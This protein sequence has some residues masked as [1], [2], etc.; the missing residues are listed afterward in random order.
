MARIEYTR[1]FVDNLLK[2][3]NLTKLMELHGIDVKRGHGKND[4]YISW[5]CTHKKD[6][7]D[8]GRID[9]NKQTYKC[10]ACMPKEMGGKNAIHFLREYAGKSY[11]EAIR[12]LAKEAGVDIPDA[13]PVISETKRRKEQALKLAAEFYQAQGMLEYLLSRGISESV[14]KKHNAGYA[15]GGRALREHLEKFGFTKDEMTEWRLINHRGLDFHFHRAILPVYLNGKVVDLYG[16]ATDD[17]KA[18][19]KHL[20]LYGDQLGG[21]DK[22]NPKK[23]VKI[24]ESAID[25][26]VAESHGLDNGVD[27]GGAKKFTSVHAKLLK[28]KGVDK[29][30]IIFDGDKGGLEGALLT[31]ELLE[32][33]GIKVSVARLPEGMDPA[34]MLQTQGRDALVNHI[35]ANNQLYPE[36]KLFQELDKYDMAAIEKYLAKRKQKEATAAADPNLGKMTQLKEGA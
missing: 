35:N 32:N 29:A 26:L 25:R 1:E 14:L 30:V 23:I 13:D 21:V 9:K 10:N 12:F 19:Q 33:E 22:I 8:H 34:E 27:P 16:R 15:P 3:V 6:N 20:Y 31:G 28:R 4:F 11:D 7:Y 5:C 2:S 17:G 36:F 24:F 18:G